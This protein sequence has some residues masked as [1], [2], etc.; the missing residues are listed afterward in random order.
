M[1]WSC[2][3]DVR[4]AVFARQKWWKVLVW[5]INHCILCWRYCW[6]RCWMLQDMDHMDASCIFYDKVG[7]VDQLEQ[8]KICILAVTSFGIV[9][10]TIHY[11]LMVSMWFM[12]DCGDVLRQTSP[13][14]LSIK[15]CPLYMYRTFDFSCCS[16]QCIPV[17][18]H[19]RMNQL[20]AKCRRVGIPFDLQQYAAGF[21]WDRTCKL[22][23]TH[24][25]LTCRYV[26][27]PQDFRLPFVISVL[28]VP[29]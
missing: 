12:Y 2:G 19:R 29:Q 5:S 8:S 9:M 23:D 16:A 4:L 18:K 1:I 3:L 24:T 27:I 17:N 25:I 20:T 21:N 26:Y 28:T 22:A 10:L 11:D 7:R 13:D 6:A 15:E 14:V